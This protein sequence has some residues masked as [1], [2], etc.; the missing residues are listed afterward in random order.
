MKNEKMKKWKKNET[1][2]MI[3][4]KEPIVA[5]FYLFTFLFFYFYYICYI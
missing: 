4:I 3:L 2:S 5:L 1:N